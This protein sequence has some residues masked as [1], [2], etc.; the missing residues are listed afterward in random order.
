[1]ASTV[2]LRFFRYR[3]SI[4][5]GCRAPVVSSSIMTMTGPFVVSG[6][7]VGV[8]VDGPIASDSARVRLAG[9]SASTAAGTDGA[10]GSGAICMLCSCVWG[11]AASIDGGLAAS[12]TCAVVFVDGGSPADAGNVLSSTGLV[13]NAPFP[14]LVGREPACCGA[15]GVDMVPV[16][17]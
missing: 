15:L 14:L 12:G 10:A 16:V 13:D 4:L 1:M 9:A 3:S 11:V 17:S 6:F 8:S 2:M 7:D 5:Y